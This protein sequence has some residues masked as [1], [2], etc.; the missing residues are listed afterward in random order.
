MY[1]EYLDPND[2][3]DIMTRQKRSPAFTAFHGNLI[4]LNKNI[5][6]VEE[7][8]HGCDEVPDIIGISET[9]L[10]DNADHTILPGY[11]FEGMCSETDAGG[12]G[13]YINNVY[14]YDVRDDLC[15]NVDKCEEIWVEV[16]TSKRNSA[17]PKNDNL[18]VA[19]L[20]RHPGSQYTEF[21]DKLC[22]TV[23]TLNK[24]KTR[25][26]VLGDINIDLLQYNLT[27]MLLST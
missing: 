25:Y 2:I 3:A 6:L 26:V 4:S 10:N 12:V 21:R 15:I 23:D 18:V 8:F 1:C 19:V 11:K 9:K 27:K 24:G 13:V 22:A 5:H 16:H 7:L 14:S 17:P 20:Y